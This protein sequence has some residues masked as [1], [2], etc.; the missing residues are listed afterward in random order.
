M[1][2]QRYNLRPGPRANRLVEKKNKIS[3]VLF[4]NRGILPKYDRSVLK[5]K[6]KTFLESI[7]RKLLS[8]IYSTAVHFKLRPHH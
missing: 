5:K 7:W 2:S 8:I 3:E 1:I 6:Y 4:K